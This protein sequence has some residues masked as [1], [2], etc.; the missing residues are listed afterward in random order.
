MKDI[1]EVF[2]IYDPYIQ[3]YYNGKRFGGL[4]FAKKYVT[5]ESAVVEVGNILSNDNKVNFLNIE[6]LYII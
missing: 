4:L 6:K 1:R 3:R 5:R 2:V